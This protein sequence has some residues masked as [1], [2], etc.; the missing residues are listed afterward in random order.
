MMFLRGGRAELLGFFLEKLPQ[1][2]GLE[3]STNVLRA[4]GGLH[5]IARLV[6][7]QRVV[8]NEADE[9][10]EVCA[11]LDFAGLELVLD[12][13]EVHGM[14]NHVEIVGNAQRGGIDG[15]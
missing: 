10:E 8:E 7:E 12:G 3:A 2:L 14:F 1:S 9:L 11:G 6:V 13:G 15:L 5:R 4:K